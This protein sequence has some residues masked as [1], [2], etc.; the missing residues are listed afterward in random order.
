MKYLLNHC[1]PPADLF[2]NAIPKGESCCCCL[3]VRAGGFL[4][5][6]AHLAFGCTTFGVVTW[7]IVVPMMDMMAVD[8]AAPT[9]NL[10]YA[11]VT[12]AY[13]QSVLDIWLAGMLAIAIKRNHLHTLLIYQWIRAFQCALFLINFLMGI[14][15]MKPYHLIWGFMYAFTLSKFHYFFYK[16]I[17]FIFN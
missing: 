1:P 9:I 3:N 17:L 12:F 15:I 5:A 4:I 7:F 14:F 10:N 11:F 2:C 13:V 8:L 6:G 16:L